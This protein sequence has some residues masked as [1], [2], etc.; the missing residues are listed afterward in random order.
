MRA[1]SRWEDK[2]RTRRSEESDQFGGHASNQGAKGRI[3]L[4]TL[5]LN[6]TSGCGWREKEFGRKEQL[7]LTVR[8][9]MNIE[10]WLE[11]ELLLVRIRILISCRRYV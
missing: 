10:Y 11:N 1:Q 8:D 6:L 9:S 3:F 7:G 5:S 4:V 2:K